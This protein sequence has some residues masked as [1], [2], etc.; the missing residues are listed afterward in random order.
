MSP[1][2][3]SSGTTHTAT[4]RLVA[5][6]TETIGQIHHQISTESVVACILNIVVRCSTEGISGLIEDIIAFDTDSQIFNNLTAYFG[7]PDESRL[8]VA[9]FITIVECVGTISRKIDNVGDIGYD[10]CVDIV[11]PGR[12]DILCRNSLP[13]LRVASISA[14][15]DLEN[16][17]TI[18]KSE[19]FGK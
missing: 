18:Y 12:S 9:L 7:I 16:V 4:H 8:I 1:T 3:T 14:N 10:I 5:E 2:H 13:S 6:S 19:V 17:I 11:G 15:G